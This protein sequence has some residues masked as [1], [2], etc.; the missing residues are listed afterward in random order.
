MDNYYKNCPPKSYSRGLTNYKNPWVN[1]EL[2]KNKN[3]I[4]RDDDYRL[5]LQMNGEKLMDAEWL[6][7]RNTQSCWNN[8]CVHVYPTRQNP[9]TFTE[10]R[11]RANLLFKSSVLPDS[12]KCPNYADY[13]MTKTKLGSVNIVN[14]CNGNC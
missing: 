1:N 7:L 12:F 6:H 14:R 13:R 9:T 10:E 4:I 8:A 3:E 11:E 5:F 2:I